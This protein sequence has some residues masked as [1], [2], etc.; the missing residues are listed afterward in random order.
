[1]ARS[2]HADGA[3]EKSP[4]SAKSCLAG[5][6]ALEAKGSEDPKG[7][8]AGSAAGPGAAAGEGAPKGLNTLADAALV[9]ISPGGGRRLVREPPA[10]ELIE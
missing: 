1:M 9:D 5:A 7:F 6:V 10:Y 8:V 4:Q 2:T 3:L